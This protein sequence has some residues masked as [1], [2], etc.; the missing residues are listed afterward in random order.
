MHAQIGRP[1]VTWRI[2]CAAFS[3]T[4]ILRAR[5]MPSETYYMELQYLTLPL[6]VEISASGQ[7]HS[8]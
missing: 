2:T 5:R 1:M 3:W 7:L 6:F 8:N 4:Q